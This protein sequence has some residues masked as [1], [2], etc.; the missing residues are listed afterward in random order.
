MHGLGKENGGQHLAGNSLITSAP[1][2]PR[3]A[4]ADSAFEVFKD[5]RDTQSFRAGQCLST[6]HRR[7]F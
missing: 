7:V 4:P 3:A 2:P 6:V 5:M 1:S